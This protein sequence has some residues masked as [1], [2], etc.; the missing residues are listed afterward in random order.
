MDVV[1]TL[2]KRFGLANWIAEGDPAGAPWSGQFYEFSI[3]GGRPNI[4]AGERVYVVYDNLLRGYAP[5]AQLQWDFPE[6][7]GYG[8]GCL[9]RGGDAVAVTIL[10]T[11]QGFRGWRYRWWETD[12]ER[13]FPS[14]NL[15]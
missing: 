8:R 13:P 12:E 3:G 11:I 10:T 15:A 7:R 14:W 1:V 5:L 9:V 6:G 2:P 4:K